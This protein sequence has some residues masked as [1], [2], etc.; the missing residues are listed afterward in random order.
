MYVPVGCIKWDVEGSEC[1]NKLE[2]GWVEPYIHMSICLV[3]SVPCG[4]LP[5]VRGHGVLVDHEN[6][7]MPGYMVHCAGLVR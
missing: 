1:S 6:I 4:L 7:K 3:S 2:S 5:E